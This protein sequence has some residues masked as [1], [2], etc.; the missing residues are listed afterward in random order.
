M[1]NATRLLGGIL[2]VAGTTIGAGMLALPVMT[3]FAGFYPSILLFSLCWLLMLATAF[4][5]LDVNLAVKEGTNLV[6]MAQKTLGSFGK[7]IS[8]IFYLLLL[9]SLNAAYISGS[10]PLFNDALQHLSGHSLPSWLAPL[11][12]PVLF[13]GFV[14]LGTIGVDYINRL[15]M[16]G[17]IVSYFLLAGSVPAHLEVSLLQHTDWNALLIAIPVVITSF[18]Y[19]IIIPSL[20][21]YL[22]HDA[23]QLRWTI[24][25][26]SAI[27][28][29]VYILWQ[30]LVIGT[31][32]LDL[33]TEAWKNGDPSTKPLS[34]LLNQPL[35]KIGARFFSF[36]AIVTSFLG[37]S[38]GLSDFLR[39]GFK[40]KKNWKGRLISCLLVFVPP[41]IF[42]YTYQR[43]FY[44]AL[45]YA[46][47]FVAVLL[48]LLPVAMA[49]KLN[50]S[51]YKHPWGK[52]VLIFIGL[53]CI[54]I[55]VVDILAEIGALHVKFNR[56]S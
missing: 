35:I 8:W 5:F 53:L 36:F 4:F 50:K 16:L 3:A 12:L 42:V 14:Y 56:A 52:A 21:I 54:G 44:I 39:D 40:L 9:Y 17:L 6:S 38:L 48:G 2:L 11:C 32:P 20:S 10:A 23:K 28:L 27:P 51:F 47:A 41:L 34:S 24:V 55:I 33:L 19:H 49:W 46:G 18:G 30:F 13:G 43:G 15:L 26:G 22:K 25:I 1:S 37:V 45:Q 31:V 29:L 7:G